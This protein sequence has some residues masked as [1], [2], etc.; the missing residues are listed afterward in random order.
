M[1]ALRG[2]ASSA[3]LAP[4][5]LVEITGYGGGKRQTLTL[6]VS[7]ADFF[8]ANARVYSA[9]IPIMLGIEIQEFTLWPRSGER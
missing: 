5:A 4:T 8:P 3:K 9:L 6:R 1:L 7:A 2:F